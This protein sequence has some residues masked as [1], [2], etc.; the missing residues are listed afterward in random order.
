ME[1]DVDEQRPLK[2][3]IKIKSLS[4]YIS[5]SHNIDYAVRTFGNLLEMDEDTKNNS[6]FID[7]VVLIAY[8]SAN[9]IPQK[10]KNYTG[11]SLYI[12]SVSILSIL[13]KD[14]VRQKQSPRVVLDKDQ[15]V[16][17]ISL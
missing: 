10:L 4:P 16:Q 5:T 7:V 1:G 14:Q 13:S 15:D 8:K 6:Q 9:G 11:I 2:V 17:E 3:W 12:V